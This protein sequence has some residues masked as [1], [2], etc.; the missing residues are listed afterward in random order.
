MNAPNAPSAKDVQAFW[1]H[2]AALEAEHG[3]ELSDEGKM[4]LVAHIGEYGFNPD[5]TRQGF[6]DIA[7]AITGAGADYEEPEGDYVE[8][9][10]SLDADEQFMADMTTDLERLQAKLGRQLTERELAGIEERMGEGMRKLGILG[11]DPEA[12]LESFYGE[13]GRSVPDMDNRAARV[14]YQVE[15]VQDAERAAKA[16]EPQDHAWDLDNRADRQAYMA[17][18]FNGGEV[19]HT[20][21]EYL[22][23]GEE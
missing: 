10:P 19:E 13:Q 14:A 4:A 5:A 18:R 22:D 7:A 23:G 21:G 12:A 8:G 2:V 15:R 16:D 9:E 6:A 17:H 20:D 11:A 1:N 3:V